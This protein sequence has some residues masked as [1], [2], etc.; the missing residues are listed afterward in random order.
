MPAWQHFFFFFSFLSSSQNNATKQAVTVGMVLLS[1]HLWCKT[2][3]VRL[4]METCRHRSKDLTWAS[5]G[6]AE[7]IVAF[8][9]FT[10][11]CGPPYSPLAFPLSAISVYCWRGKRVKKKNVEGRGQMLRRMG[12]KWKRGKDTAEK[13]KGTTWS[14]NAQVVSQGLRSSGL[15]R[16]CNLKETLQRNFR[17]LF[18]LIESGDITAVRAHW[19]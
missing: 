2:E 18:S 9:C 12:E 11:Q 1:K 8:Q 3:T 6:G 14:Q 10:A 16:S 17:G 19:A 7:P 4:W 15:W 5:P 13:K